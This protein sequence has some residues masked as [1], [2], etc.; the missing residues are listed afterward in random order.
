MD[1][2]PASLAELVSRYGLLA[3]FIGSVLEGEGVLLV[4]GILV[5]QGLLP[6]AAVWGVAASGAW[7]GHLSMFLVGRVIGRQRIVA[8]S[9]WFARRLDDADQIMHAYPRAAVVLLQYLYG[10]RIVGAI[11]FGMTRFPLGRFLRYQLPNCLVWAALIVSLGDVAGTVGERIFEG[12]AKWLW[13]AASALF[14]LWLLH[15]LASARV[16][17]RR[18]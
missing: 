14:L 8:G 7:I 4:A 10:M 1:S 5:S 11:A 15:R 18:T 6:F 9:A 12:W 17:G 2:I 3:V 13:L 16:G